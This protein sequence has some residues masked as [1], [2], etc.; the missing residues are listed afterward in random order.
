M[1]TTGCTIAASFTF[2]TGCLSGSRL[3][4]F[5]FCLGLMRHCDFTQN[6]EQAQS[7]L[8]AALT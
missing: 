7:L 5:I 2:I 3:A 1:T 6:L 8:R 4:Y